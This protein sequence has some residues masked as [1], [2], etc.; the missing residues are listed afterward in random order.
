MQSWRAMNWH[1]SYVLKVSKEKKD[2]IA[3]IHTP[4]ACIVSLLPSWTCHLSQKDRSTC[5]V[6]RCWVWMLVYTLDMLL[7]PLSC[8]KTTYTRH[9]LHRTF[10]HLCWWTRRIL[11]WKMMYCCPHPFFPHWSLPLLQ[12]WQLLLPLLV[13]PCML[14]RPPIWWI[15]H[16]HNR[17]NI[18]FQRFGAAISM[19][20][21]IYIGMI[22]I[23]LARKAF[24][25]LCFLKV[26]QSQM[27][28]TRSYKVLVACVGHEWYCKRH[29]CLS[30]IHPCWFH[31]CTIIK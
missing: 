19:M 6:Y 26:I 2:P 24:H 1:D 10:L 27:F 21:N 18:Y 28:I 11:H 25:Y 5:A 16:N 9:L 12:S 31:Q 17:M 13:L 22:K 14:A 15:S 23:T 3:V 20:S 8:K 4:H 7:I 30:I 29:T